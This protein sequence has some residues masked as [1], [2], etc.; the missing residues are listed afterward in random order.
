MLKCLKVNAREVCDG[1]QNE[2]RNHF[3]YFRFERDALMGRLSLGEFLAAL[4]P[5]S[6]HLCSAGNPI[7]LT[8]K[9]HEISPFADSLLIFFVRCEPAASPLLPEW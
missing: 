6:V 4:I 3:W 1:N 2:V 7:V 9:K 5:L 8:Q